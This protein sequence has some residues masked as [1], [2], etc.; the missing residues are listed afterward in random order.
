MAV[1]GCHMGEGHAGR[2]RSDRA[3]DGEAGV[4]GGLMSDDAARELYQII[5][6]SVHDMLDAYRLEARAGPVSGSVSG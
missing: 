6:A 1:S 3:D 2:G 5:R 4:G